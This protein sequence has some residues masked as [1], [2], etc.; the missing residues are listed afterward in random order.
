M[1]KI[2]KQITNKKNQKKNLNGLVH[3]QST[4]NNTIITITNLKGDTLI[5]SSAG[6]VGFKGTR[7]STLFAAQVV[8]EK[9][10]SK[11][12]N[13]GL[14]NIDI[15]IKGQ[16][17]GREVIIRVFENFGFNVT[18]IQDK[19]PIPHNGCRPRKRRRV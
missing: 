14:K 3:I 8:A 5:W 18:S 19:T 1:I 16:G 11:A 15:L 9:I 4:L 6:N 17:L 13:I 2:L 12:L 7:K 10:A